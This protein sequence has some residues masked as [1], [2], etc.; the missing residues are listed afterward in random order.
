MSR[1]SEF[2]FSGLREDDAAVRLGG[3]YET[4]SGSAEGDRLSGQPSEMFSN[5]RMGGLRE[6]DA[7]LKLSGLREDDAT[8]RMEGA[9]AD[10]AESSAEGDL[11]GLRED[12]A[13]VRMEG[14]YA[15]RAEGE[16]ESDLGG[17]R[18]DDASVRLMGLREDDASIRLGDIE[19]L[20]A[21]GARIDQMAA[22]KVGPGAGRGLKVIAAQAGEEAFQRAKTGNLKSKAEVEKIV[23]D[24]LNRRLESLKQRVADMPKLIDATVSFEMKRLDKRLSKVFSKGTSVAGLRL[25][26]ILRGL[27]EDDADLRLMGLREDDANLRM[28]GLREDDAGVRMEGLREDDASVVLSGAE[29]V[30]PK[31]GAEGFHERFPVTVEIKGL[32]VIRCV[33][34]RNTMNGL[35]DFLK[36]AMSSEEYLAKLAQLKTAWASVRRDLFAL[37]D[38]QKSA[39]EKTMVT[40]EC[41]V[42]EY[43][44]ATTVYIAEGA[45]GMTSTRINRVNRIET[46]LPTIRKLIDQAKT[47]GPT[48]ATTSPQQVQQTAAADVDQRIAAAGSENVLVSTVLPVAGGAALVG[49]ALLVIL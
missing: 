17:L 48:A 44:R 20:S 6:D 16:S 32:G 30:P 49:T 42:G 37:T 25:G 22:A 41:E 18:E 36:P 40:M 14:A 2:R 19:T 4:A 24:R 43:D 23:R 34:Y 15:P 12:D 10:A 11:R 27:R 35:F 29:E 31:L 26:C 45:A 39:I 9:Y 1:N 46:G 5:G 7:N 38:Q 8:V 33:A 28:E 21:E 47:F 13:S 3:A